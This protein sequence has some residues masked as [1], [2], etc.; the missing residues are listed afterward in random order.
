MAFQFIF[1]D[2]FDHYATGDIDKKYGSN[3]PDG[4][5]N[6]TSPRTG[7]QAC[8]LVSLGGPTT[9]NFGK[10]GNL[11]VGH[12]INPGVY[13]GAIMIFEQQAASDFAC[14]AQINGDGSISV[15][16]HT[17][18]QPGQTLVTTPPAV[19]QLGV[20]AYV[21]YGIVF[22]EAGSVYVR[23]NEVLVA[24]AVGVPTIPLPSPQDTY[25]DAVSLSGPNAILGSVHYHDDYYIGTDDAGEPQ[26]S[27]LG[28]I[29]IYPYIPSANKTPLDW[30]PS[31]NTNY[32]QTSTIP[33]NPSDYVSD[34]TVGDI[35]QYEMQP[36]PGHGPVGVF[37]IVGGQIVICAAL[38]AAGSGA[39]AP[40]IGGSNEGTSNTLSTSFEMYTQGYLINPVTGSPF[41]PDDFTDAT[42]MGPEVSG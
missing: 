15:I 11:V 24:S 29:R 9:K 25:C 28:A 33:P 1:C 35:D 27:F 7:T 17:P 23:V 36:I 42:T 20:Y 32:Q 39:V 40:N 26:N 10:Q 18:T 13:E 8:A 38:S 5:V 30:T 31:A 6:T 34:D 41:V 22:A 14:F 21:E 4:S 12:A 3:S 37:T 19:L 16:N 2:S